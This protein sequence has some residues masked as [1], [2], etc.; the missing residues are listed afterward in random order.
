MLGILWAIAGLNIL[1]IREN[2]RFTFI[3]FVLA[4]FIILNL[5]VSGVIEF[6]SAALTRL[7]ESGGELR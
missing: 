1:G 3:V 7:K 2:A 4:A 6:D 5:I